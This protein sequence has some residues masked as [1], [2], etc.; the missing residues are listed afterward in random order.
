MTG[1]N[2]LV[3]DVAL[4]RCPPHKQQTIHH[5]IA[6]LG[7]CQFYQRH[8]SQHEKKKTESSLDNFSHKNLVALGCNH[9]QRPCRRDEEIAHLLKRPCTMKP[10]LNSNALCYSDNKQDRW[11]QQ[12]KTRCVQDKRISRYA[13]N[14]MCVNDFQLRVQSENI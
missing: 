7:A 3:F 1:C 10:R 4:L 11:H 8:L 6:A 5:A 12:T 13:T 9:I 2:F 14:C